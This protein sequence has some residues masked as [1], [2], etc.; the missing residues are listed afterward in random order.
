MLANELRFHGHRA[1]T[2][3]PNLPTNENANNDFMPMTKTN[4]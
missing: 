3:L 1:T 4:L 2:I